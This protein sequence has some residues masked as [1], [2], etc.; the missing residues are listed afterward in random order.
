MKRV[1]TI[2]DISCLGKCS[3]TVALPIISAFGIET[4]VIPTAVL[5]THTVFDGFTFRDLTCD[6]LPIKRHWEKENFKFDAIYTGY[7]GSLKQLDI[8]K[9]YFKTFKN[10]DTVI[11]VDPV[12]ADNGVLYKGFTLEFAKK[13]TEL[14]SFADV[15]VPNLTEACFM[16]NK[17]YVPNGYTR[18]Y[19]KEILI[20]LTD[21]GAKKAVLTGIGF[22]AG[23]TGVVGYDKET[24]EFFEYYH[25]RIDACYHGTGDIFSSAFVGGLVKGFSLLDALKIAAD[26]TAECINVTAKD[27]N[28]VTYGVEFELALPKLINDIYKNG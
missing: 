4:C 15:I 14:C 7:L 28:A 10:D 18:E 27:A 1:V 8:V 20:G 2:Q 22:K 25:K 11:V 24:K 6:M 21:L 26:Y 3:L 12:M 23:E 9:D 19:I 13:M 16:L 17:K 5:S